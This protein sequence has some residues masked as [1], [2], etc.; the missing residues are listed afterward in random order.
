MEKGIGGGG[1]GKSKRL[2]AAWGVQMDCYAP[3]LSGGVGGGGEM[4]TMLYV[5]GH[6]RI[7]ATRF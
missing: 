5:H 1:K 3:A 4:M 7:H 2:L 6:T